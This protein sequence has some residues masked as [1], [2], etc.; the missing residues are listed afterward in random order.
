[1]KRRGN[2]ANNYSDMRVVRSKNSRGTSRYTWDVVD[3]DG[4]I[5][6]GGF[7]DLL[8]AMLTALRYGAE[9]PLPEDKKG[10]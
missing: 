2:V 8:A 5:V 7:F 9:F 4:N 6:E 10:E 1:M 3:V